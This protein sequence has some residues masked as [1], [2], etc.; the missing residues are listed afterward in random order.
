MLEDVV[1]YSFT[2][3]LQTPFAV[4][5]VGTKTPPIAEKVAVDGAVV[6]IVNALQATVALSGKHVAAH[7]AARADGRSRLQVPLAGVGF[8]ERFIG[9][10]ARRA[11]LHQ[12]AAEGVFE[13][14][15]IGT[16]EVHA[17]SRTKRLQILATGIVAIKPHAAEAGDATI[18][19]VVDEWPELLVVEGSLLTAVGAHGVAGHDCHVLEMT[20]TAFFTDGTVVRMVLHQPLDHRC[21]ELARLI[22]RNRYPCAIAGRCHARHRQTSLLVVLVAIMNDSALSARANG[23]QG[24]VPA[25]VRQL[26]L[27]REAGME[28]VLAGFDLIGF[29]V[30]VDRYHDSMCSLAVGAMPGTNVFFEIFPKIL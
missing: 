14:A 2:R 25:E 18:H 13:R 20:L 1:F 8:G 6:A 3:Q 19:L 15:I 4:D 30:D 29:V 26:K 16:A 5:E 17:V 12:V 27:V 11:D 28:Q 22:R 10:H 23:S 9:E 21:S 7:R 24:W